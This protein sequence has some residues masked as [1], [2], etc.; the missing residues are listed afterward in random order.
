MRSLQINVQ[1]DCGVG[2]G[3]AELGKNILQIVEIF[4]ISQWK[5]KCAGLTL[6]SNLSICQVKHILGRMD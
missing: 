5:R 4:M 2:E 6:P 3:G 1:V